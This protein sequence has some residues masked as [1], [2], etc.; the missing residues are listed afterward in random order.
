MGYVE[1]LTYGIVLLISLTG[2]LGFIFV[3][4]GSQ[5]DHGRSTYPCKIYIH[6]PIIARPV[7]GSYGLIDI[8]QPT[9]PTYQHSATITIGVSKQ[10]MPY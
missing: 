7:G 10:G 6:T 4:S 9:H 3:V 5:R 8:N 1:P 2:R